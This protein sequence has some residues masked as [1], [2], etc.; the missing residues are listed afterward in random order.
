MTRAGG[1]LDPDATVVVVGASLA[2]LRAA[3]E[4][5]HE[6]HRG[7]VVVVGDEAHAPYDRPPLSKQLL[8][9]KWEVDRIHHHAPDRLDTLGIEFL[10]GRRA[11]S[12]DAATRTIGLDDGTELAYGGLV[13]ATGAR[14]R[15]LP[16]GEG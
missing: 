8:A 4:V 2:G 5:R 13:V 14:P 9:G 7:P 12:L 11:V 16:G 1:P 6:R 15:A 3:E 10:L